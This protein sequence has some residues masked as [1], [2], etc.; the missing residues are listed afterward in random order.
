MLIPSCAPVVVPCSDCRLCF[1]HLFVKRVLATAPRRLAARNNAQSR[2][3]P[4]RLPPSCASMT[5]TQD[6]AVVDVNP[7]P[8][9]V[10]GHHACLSLTND[11]IAKQICPSEL[12]FY[13]EL[14]TTFLTLA[15][16]VPQFFG[17]CLCL[18]GLHSRSSQRSMLVC[19]GTCLVHPV[20][21]PLPGLHDD[22]DGMCTAPHLEIVF[23]SD[24]D[25]CPFGSFA[26]RLH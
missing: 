11:R 7:Y 20:E 24:M 15:P 12:A 1:V 21:Q 14:H 4:R 5:S 17:V 25:P 9:Q 18:G 10:G 8:H 2:S 3:S 16:F 6:S 23:A 19:V 22:S 26:F 13:T